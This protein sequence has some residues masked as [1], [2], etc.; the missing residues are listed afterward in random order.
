MKSL[1]TLFL[2]PILLFSAINSSFSKPVPKT[3]HIQPLGKVSPI[4][5][6][7]VKESVKTFYGY[8]CAVK[9]QLEVTNAML[10]RVK[11]RI[12]ANKAL[13]SNKTSENLLFITEGDISFN[14]DVANPE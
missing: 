6:Q 14:K 8:D 7:L 5:V 11:K 4:Y 1:K 9:P 3:I 10:S 13:R 2:I 12:D